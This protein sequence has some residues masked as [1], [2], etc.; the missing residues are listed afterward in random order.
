MDEPKLTPKQEG[1]V[2]DY[3]E[4]GNATEAARRNYNPTTDGSARA[5]GS[6]NLTKPNIIER[7]RGAQSIAYTTIVDLAQNAEKEDVRLRAAQDIVDRTE[8]KA[9]QKNDLTSGGKPIF[10]IPSMI[11][12]KNDINTEAS[13][14]SEG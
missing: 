11:A 13:G 8:G 5:I 4:T 2:K 14:N 1:F 12:E 3:I 10:V 9:T 7:L 6:E